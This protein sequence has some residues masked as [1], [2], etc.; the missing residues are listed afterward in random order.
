NGGIAGWS[1]DDIVA[2]LGTG[3]AGHTI[4][5]VRMGEVVGLSTQHMREEDLSAI[6]VYLKS[7]DD[8]PRAPGGTRDRDRLAA[9]E[10]IF[11]DNCAACHQS[12]GSGVPELF[13]RLDGSN[14]VNA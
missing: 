4:A 14:K 8:V 7:L 10:A 6:A 12:D 11:F 5:M 2:F 9:G 3:R 1:E 13:A